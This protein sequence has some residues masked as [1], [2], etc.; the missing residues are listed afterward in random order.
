M[1]SVIRALACL[2]LPPVGY[3][4]S[5]RGP[6]GTIIASNMNDNTATMI[7][8]ASGRAITTLPTGEGPHEVAVSHDGRWALVSNYG[9]RGKPGKSIT[10]IDVQRAAVARTISIEGYQRPHGMAFLPGDSLV[11][12]T[13]EASKMVLV[14]RVADGSIVKTLS[15]NGR[16]THM[17]S[18]ARSGDRMVT[19]NIADNSV[20]VVSL[21]G[22]E[23]KVIPVAH[24]PEGIA[25]SPDGNTA[26]VGSNRDSVVL[27]VNTNSGAVLDTLHEFVI[28]YR[29]AISPDA[30]RAIITDP[31]K[32]T[33]QIY[34]A[35]TRKL[36]TTIDVPR[37]SVVATSEAPGSPAPEG[38]TI[39]PDSKWAFVTLQG[40]NRVVTVDIERGVITS[41]ATT[42]TWSD[43][44]AFS[45]VTRTK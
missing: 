3:A 18:L 8:A 10:V 15:T 22:G 29:M 25:I 7:D 1:Q 30:R 6:A 23:P 2:L 16:A 45:L 34:D 43:G 35:S 37:D 20:S 28:P 5:A 38:V 12:V 17:L 4:Q 14:V 36:R 21:A 32:G 24:Q 42:G 19:A 13:A 41:W 33:I 31:A 26:W 11:A 40:R 27:I 44:V 39:S 9:P